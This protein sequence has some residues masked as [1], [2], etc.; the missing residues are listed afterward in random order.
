MRDVGALHHG[1]LPVILLPVHNSQYFHDV[2]RGFLTCTVLVQYSWS[3]IILDPH[4]P[5]NRTLIPY[6]LLVHRAVRA[7]H[8]TIAIPL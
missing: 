5:Q 8:S 4:L 6:Q 1:A 7:L 3:Y 2:F